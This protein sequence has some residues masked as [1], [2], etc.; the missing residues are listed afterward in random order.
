MVM[1]WM[2]GVVAQRLFG[3]A[4]GRVVVVDT[5]CLNAALLVA[6]LTFFSVSRVSFTS[7]CYE[8]G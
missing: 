2:D 1:L 6:R 8:E 3:R 5:T 4:V 7:S